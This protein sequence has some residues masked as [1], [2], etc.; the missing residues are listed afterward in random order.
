MS[1]VLVSPRET[2]LQKQVIELAESLR[3]IGWEFELYKTGARATHQKLLDEI[4][5]LKAKLA[6]LEKPGLEPVAYISQKFVVGSNGEMLGISDKKLLRLG[7]PHQYAYCTPL[8][9]KEQL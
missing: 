3:N 6:E 4:R 8:Y 5:E 7:K 9:L 1:I 2:E